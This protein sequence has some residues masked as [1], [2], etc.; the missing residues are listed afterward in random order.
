MNI[1]DRYEAGECNLE[2]LTERLPGLADE[3]LEAD[4][5]YDK[6]C[7][8]MELIFGYHDILFYDNH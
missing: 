8:Y 7:F 1:I 6:L 2:E 5:G 4:V 3:S